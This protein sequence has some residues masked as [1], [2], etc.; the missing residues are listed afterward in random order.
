MATPTHNSVDFIVK[1]LY[2]ETEHLCGGVDNA[3]LIGLRT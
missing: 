1:G 3:I 2:I